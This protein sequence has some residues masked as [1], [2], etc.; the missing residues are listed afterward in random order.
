MPKY[1]YIF[2]DGEEHKDAEVS[3]NRM[4]RHEQYQKER[5]FHRKITLFGEEKDLIRSGFTGDDLIDMNRFIPDI[6]EQ[7]E[8]SEHFMKI[9]EEFKADYPVD[10][11]IMYKYYLDYPR[12]N[13]EQIAAE[14]NITKQAVSYRLKNA[15]KKLKNLFVSNEI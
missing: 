12:M 4:G 7:R 13:M 15:L 6:I 11:D 5:D 1:K 8:A 2:F 3:W 14:Y 9:L 10:Y